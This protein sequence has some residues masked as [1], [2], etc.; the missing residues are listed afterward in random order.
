MVYPR[1]SVLEHPISNRLVVSSI[2][3][4]GSLR[5]SSSEKEQWTFKPQVVGSNPTS[6]FI[7]TPVV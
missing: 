7:F 5:G 1:S 2:L 3:T 6:R 4:G